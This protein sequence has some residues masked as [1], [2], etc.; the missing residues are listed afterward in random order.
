MD[1]A[2]LLAADAVLEY[3]SLLNAE[4]AALIAAAAA[5]DAAEIEARLWMARRTLQAAIK[6]WREACPRETIAEAAE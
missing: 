4:C 5:G 6:T 3:A 2:Q 1:D